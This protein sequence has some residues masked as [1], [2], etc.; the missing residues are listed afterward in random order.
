MHKIS[1]KKRIYSPTATGLTVWAGILGELGDFI[2]RVLLQWGD[3]LRK[4]K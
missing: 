2:A 4:Q 3:R 1:H